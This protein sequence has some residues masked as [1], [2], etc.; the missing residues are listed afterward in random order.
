L[1]C[2]LT[3]RRQAARL[4]YFF[5]LDA[6]IWDEEREIAAI[7]SHDPTYALVWAGSANWRKAFP[8][9][10]KFVDATFEPHEKLG[11][12]EVLKKRATG[13]P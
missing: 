7:H 4:D 12:V 2:F 6:E 10:S 5:V 11:M 13:G 1:Y 9:L 8:K 3:G